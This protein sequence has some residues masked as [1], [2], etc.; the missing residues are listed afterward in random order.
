MCQDVVLFDLSTMRWLVFATSSNAVRCKHTTTL[1]RGKLMLFGGHDGK[2]FLNTISQQDTDALY[3]FLAETAPPRKSMGGALPGMEAPLKG[4]SHLI[5]KENAIAYNS[6][7]AHV[8]P[9]VVASQAETVCASLTFLASSQ[10]ALMG[11][12]GDVRAM[13]YRSSGSQLLT[14]MT[15][16]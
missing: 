11:A 6:D 1:V 15:S 2:T 3:R 10:L 13:P 12:S 8:K 7:G 14:Q 4:D 9:D 5:D 16:C